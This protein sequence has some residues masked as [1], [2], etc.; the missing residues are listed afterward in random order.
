MALG[1]RLT[2]AVDAEG[3]V[4]TTSEVSGG[5]SLVTDAVT[6]AFDPNVALQVLQS[7]FS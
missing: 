6:T 7:T 4:S 5:L 2:I 3:V 1:R